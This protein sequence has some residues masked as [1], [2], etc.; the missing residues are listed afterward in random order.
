MKFFKCFLVVFF[1]LTSQLQAQTSAIDDSI[2]IIGSRTVKVTVP[3]SYFG[4]NDRIK[5]YMD[6]NLS[7]G[8][9]INWLLQDTK[10]SDGNGNMLFPSSMPGKYACERIKVYSTDPKIKLGNGYVYELGRFQADKCASAS[11]ISMVNCGT[12]LKAAPT[13]SPSPSPTPVYGGLP[14]SSKTFAVYSTVNC[15]AQSECKS[16]SVIDL[17]GISTAACVSTN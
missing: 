10:I 2:F 6:A 14:P 12:S 15:P 9:V 16:Q 3:E 13:G 17:P 11:K 1:S 8:L 5:P 7:D 4:W